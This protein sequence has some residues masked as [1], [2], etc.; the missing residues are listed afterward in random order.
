MKEDITDISRRTCNGTLQTGVVHV[1]CMIMIMYNLAY[2]RYY[3]IFNMCN[4]DIEWYSTELL[5]N[6]SGISSYSDGLSL[7]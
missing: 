5:R 3:V 4:G 1:S 2:T 6:K 7:N